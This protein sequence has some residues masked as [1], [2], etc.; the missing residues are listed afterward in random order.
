MAFMAG[1]VATSISSQAQISDDAPSQS[2]LAVQCSVS[3]GFPASN[4]GEYCRKLS[5]TVGLLS[6]G[7]QERVFGYVPQP[8]GYDTVG[9]SQGVG[10]GST[11]HTS[12]GAGG[13]G[14]IHRGRD[15]RAPSPSGAQQSVTQNE[16]DNWWDGLLGWLEELLVDQNDDSRDLEKLKEESDDD[17]N[18]GRGNDPDRIDL[19][20]PGNKK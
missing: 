12:T 8:Y 20:N 14:Y 2:L 10:V 16:G 3:S 9:S 18:N 1:L 15:D 6:P 13:G 5:K 17:G 19:S 11:K 4:Y 7:Q